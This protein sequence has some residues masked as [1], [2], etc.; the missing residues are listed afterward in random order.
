MGYLGRPELSA[1]RF[2]A[3]PFGDGTHVPHRRR[4][5][6]AGRRR[7]RTW[8]RADDQI[9]IRGQRV[10]LG[11]IETVLLAQPGG[12][13]VVHA[14]VLGAQA[15]RMEGGEDHRQLVAY[16]VLRDGASLDASA[17]RRT[18]SAAPAGPH[19]AGG[20]RPNWRNCR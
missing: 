13:A 18:A 20:L 11:E 17:I 12:K 19:G 10:E 7:G 3:D 15:Q 14:V 8:S 16:L 1:S 4:G 9:K 2:V 5:A 6:L